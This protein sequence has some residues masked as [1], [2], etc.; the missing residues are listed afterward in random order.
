MRRPPRLAPRRQVSIPPLSPLSVWRRR[1]RSQRGHRTAPA[2]AT[3]WYGRRNG[4]GEGWCVLVRG[5]EDWWCRGGFLDLEPRRGSP[6]A[7]Q[8]EEVEGKDSTNRRW[9]GLCD[10]SAAVVRSWQHFCKGEEEESDL[11]FGIAA[12]NFY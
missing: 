1:R 3:D 11:D 4:E 12:V 5:R 2:Q 9:F 7:S 10:L 6:E 8:P